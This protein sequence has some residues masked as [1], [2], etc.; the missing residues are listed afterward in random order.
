MFGA[1]L[2]A[3]DRSGEDAGDFVLAGRGSCVGIPPV[4]VD[5]GG[6]T[7]EYEGCLAQVP[8]LEHL[9]PW[10]VVYRVL[11]SW[12]VM[13]VWPVLAVLAEWFVVVVRSSRWPSRWRF[14]R[15]NR[16]AG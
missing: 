8:K 16:Q 9:L 11:G 15:G 14:E 13:M 7:S 6:A 2:L 1:L 10:L 5:F 4:D 3:G 12:L